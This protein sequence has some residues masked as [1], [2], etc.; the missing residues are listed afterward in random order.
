MNVIQ[1]DLEPGVYVVACF[2]GDRA[3]A[4]REHSEFGMVRQM[5]VR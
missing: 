5:T 2:Y 3:S 1:A 4:G